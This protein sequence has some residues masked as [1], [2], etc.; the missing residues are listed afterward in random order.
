VPA[1]YRDVTHSD[2]ILCNG[3]LDSLAGPLAKCSS[4]F[5]AVTGLPFTTAVVS[6]HASHGIVSVASNG[7]YSP[8][9]M[10]SPAV[11]SAPVLPTESTSTTVQ[12]VPRFFQPQ[13][14][15]DV[16]QSPV[17]FTSGLTADCSGLAA[18]M[19]RNTAKQDGY[20][21]DETLFPSC[22]SLAANTT[23]TP[24]MP[25]TLQTGAAAVSKCLTA[26][27]VASAA[28]PTANMFSQM[29]SDVP[30]AAKT[31]SAVVNCQHD[32]CEDVDDDDDD[33]DE[34][35]EDDDESVSDES[36]SNQKDGG[37]YCECWRCEFFGHADVCPCLLSLSCM[38]A[39]DELTVM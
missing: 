17:R 27:T 30:P 11:F 2:V 13:F 32:V 23:G 14:F 38:L 18:K 1:V 4:S 3:W 10:P 29:K 9:K 22:Q 24:T 34:D 33:D 5:P 12:P 8:W 6:S 19:A 20:V 39:A 25:T 37:K 7:A 36:L 15:P 16:A 28:V 21:R 35:D 31:C 26:S